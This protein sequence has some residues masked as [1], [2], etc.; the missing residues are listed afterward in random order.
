MYIYKYFSP[1]LKSNS[2]YISRKMPFSKKKSRKMGGDYDM[3]KGKAQFQ[4]RQLANRLIQ[5]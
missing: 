2:G 3:N 4:W 1:N 5:V